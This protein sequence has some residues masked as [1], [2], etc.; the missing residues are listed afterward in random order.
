MNLDDRGGKAWSRGG[1]GENVAWLFLGVANTSIILHDDE[2]LKYLKDH[3]E[4][5][6]SVFTESP[7]PPRLRHNP[8]DHFSV[9]HSMS[10]S[11]CVFVL[12]TGSLRM[13][14][15]EIQEG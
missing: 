4:N 12:V 3:Q 2:F 1:D 15:A 11:V 13:C 6:R 7:P 5:F 14:V 10:R 8:T 9:S